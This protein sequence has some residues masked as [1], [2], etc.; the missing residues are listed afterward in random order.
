M[1]AHVCMRGIEEVLFYNTER[2][3][4]KLGEKERT[5]KTKWLLSF[6]TKLV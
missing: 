4:K 1:H 3:K 6:S 2:K 5:R